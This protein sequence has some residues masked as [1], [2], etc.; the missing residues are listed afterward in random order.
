[1]DHDEI[2]EINEDDQDYY[3]T[4]GVLQDDIDEEEEIRK[5]NGDDSDSDDE[6]L[7][8]A[9]FST[10]KDV[11]K[12]SS[13]IT[14]DQRITGNIMTKYEYSRIISSLADMYSGG[15]PVSPK[16]KSFVVGIID[17]IDIAE[18]HMAHRLLVPVPID[19]ERPMMGRGQ[20]VEVWNPREMYLPTD[21]ITIGLA[22]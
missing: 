18:I 12:T 7:D 10:S 1:M 20:I 3:D 8:D 9:P 17:S 2:N 21:L 4:A 11:S 16:L 22:K 13:K 14:G 15:L 19:I 5:E 6:D